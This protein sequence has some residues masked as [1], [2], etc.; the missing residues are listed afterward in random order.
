MVFLKCLH[1]LLSSMVFYVYIRTMRQC[2]YNI[3]LLANTYIHLYKCIRLC[4][5]EHKNNIALSQVKQWSAH[6]MSET[7]FEPASWKKSNSVKFCYI[8]H[9]DDADHWSKSLCVLKRF[10][11]HIDVP[12]SLPFSTLH[13]PVIKTRARVVWLNSMQR[14]SVS[15]SRCQSQ[16]PFFRIFA[17][18]KRASP[19]MIV[20]FLLELHEPQELIALSLWQPVHLES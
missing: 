17:P 3:C 12:L 6:L 18:P 13:Y 1:C 15:C 5:F 7:D 14:H 16:I 2:L 11:L 20:F 4:S 19:F 8:S 9:W 10:N